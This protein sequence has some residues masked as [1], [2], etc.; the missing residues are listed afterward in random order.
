MK[1]TKFLA[2]AAMALSAIS[3]NA[4][5]VSY[6]ATHAVG[7]ASTDFYLGKFNTGLGTLTGVEV[8]VVYSTLTGSILFTNKDAGNASVGAFNSTVSVQDPTAEGVL[9]YTQEYGYV[10]NVKTTPA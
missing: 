10:N 8:N 7:S 4:E 1:T 9:G 5:T 6:T 3:L 2:A